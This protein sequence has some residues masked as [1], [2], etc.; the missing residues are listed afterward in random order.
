MSRR[1]HAP[2]Q[3][4]AQWHITVM[5]ED[6]VEILWHGATRDRDEL[7]ALATESRRLRPEAQILIRHPMGRLYYW[8]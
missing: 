5:N 4:P 7:T 6:G 2:A 1:R 3:G 8:E